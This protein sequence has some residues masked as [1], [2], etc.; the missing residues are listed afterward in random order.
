[1]LE[2]AIIQ[3]QPS[4]SLYAVTY[5]V[6]DEGNRLGSAVLQCGPLRDEEA[7]DGLRMYEYDDRVEIPGSLLLGQ[8]RTIRLEGDPLYVRMATDPGEYHPNADE[9]TAEHLRGFMLEYL[10]SRNITYRLR[11]GGDQHFWSYRIDLGRDETELRQ[12]ALDFALAKVR[13]VH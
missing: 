1:M 10:E 6:D 11:P 13:L 3:H 5:E 9:A 8:Y 7:G 2:R 12:A 4:G